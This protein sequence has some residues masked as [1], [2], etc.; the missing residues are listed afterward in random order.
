MRY[1]DIPTRRDLKEGFYPPKTTWEDRIYIQ[2]YLRKRRAEGLA[3][4]AEEARFEG[5]KSSPG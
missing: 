2:E 4:A 3:A 5:D 1:R